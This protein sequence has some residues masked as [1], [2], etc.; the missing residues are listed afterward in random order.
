MK[1]EVNVRKAEEDVDELRSESKIPGIIYG[2]KRP[3]ST[4]IT[5]DR[6]VFLKLRKQSTEST[7]ID[8]DVDGDVVKALIGEIQ[9]HPISDEIIHVDMR[10]VEAGKKVKARIKLNFVGESPAVKTGGLIVQNRDFVQVIA[11]PA[12]LPEAIEVDLSVLVEYEQ[13]VHIGD[14]NLPEGVDVQEDDRVSIVVIRPPKKLEDIE[15]DLAS[16]VGDD[17]GDAPVGEEGEEGKEGEGEGDA[18]DGDKPAEDGK[19][20]GDDKKGD[21]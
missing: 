19:E 9:Y 6:G 4:S 12:D 1:L 17:G 18:K 21:K 14:L 11:L 3:E 5:I 20:K 13:G 2:G 7:V 8:V 10:Q 16:P 15:A